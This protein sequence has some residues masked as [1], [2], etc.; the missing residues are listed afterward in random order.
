MPEASDM[1]HQLAHRLAIVDADL[2]ERRVRRAVDQNAGELRCSQISE[3]ASFGVGARR[4]DDPVNP[5]LM[6]RGQDRKL[7]S[8][9]ILGVGKENHHAEPGAL[10]LD[11]A[12]DVSEVGISDR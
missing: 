11:R 3:C 4:Q 1:V 5:P 10:G 12:N 6:Q 9:V 2:I 8:R 7:A